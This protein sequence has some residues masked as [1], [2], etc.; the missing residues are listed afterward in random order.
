MGSMSVSFCSKT[1]IAVAL[2]NV[3]QAPV[4][5]LITYS[6][7]RYYLLSWATPVGS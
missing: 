3:S 6:A 5:A 7:I 2:P 4:F 1:A